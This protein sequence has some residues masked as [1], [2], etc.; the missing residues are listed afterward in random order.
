[1]EKVKNKSNLPPLVNEIINIVVDNVSVSEKIRIFYYIYF[2]YLR[3]HEGAFVKTIFVKPKQK[4]LKKITIKEEDNHWS[5]R[6]DDCRH[7]PK[8]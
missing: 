5:L 8:L 1:M 4:Y 3:K 6:G 7:L 2:I